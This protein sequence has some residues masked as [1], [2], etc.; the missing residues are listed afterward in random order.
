MRQKWKE[1]GVSPI[2]LPNRDNAVI[3]DVLDDRE[4]DSEDK[5]DEELEE[6]DEEESG[7]SDLNRHCLQCCM[8]TSGASD[9]SRHCPQ[10]YVDASVAS[11]STCPAAQGIVGTSRASGSSYP[12][13]QGRID[14]SVKR[15]NDVTKGSGIKMGGLMGNYFRN[16]DKK[17]GQQ[18]AFKN[19]GRHTLGCTVSYPDILNTHYSSYLEAAAETIAH[20]QFYIGYLEDVRDEKTNRKFNHLE[21][22]IYKA[23]HDNSTL[24]KLAVLALYQEAVSHS[25]ILV[26]RG[27]ANEP[28]N[29]LDLEPLHKK[30]R[31][32]IS[33]LI[34]EPSIIL[35]PGADPV[36]ATLGGLKEWKNPEAVRE[37]HRRAGEWPHLKA[38]F[39]A[40]LQG[41]LLTWEQFSSE[42]QDN[43]IIAALTPGE[44][45]LA[46]MPATN[47]V[48]EGALG[49][50]HQFSRCKPR[51]TELLFNAIFR[52][53]RNKT[54]EFRDEL[55]TTP[56]HE[57]FMKK[58][59]QLLQADGKERKRV[60]EIFEE[61][62][63]ELAEKRCRIAVQ[64]EKKKEKTG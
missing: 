56:E 39:I 30:V 15:A 28:K 43:G 1:L 38:I 45:D 9:L 47:D 55:L 32:H 23:L 20:P 64:D 10:G 37:I 29:A 34:G 31:T 60:R 2:P 62:Q 42:F 49:A 54:E 52:F 24:T 61:G 21:L 50:L 48:I 16:K 40:F 33:W 14:G 58:E 3:L 63:E 35:S 13:A 57:V 26:V 8:D 59:A 25:Y 4:R 19:H 7:A 36:G 5:D 44:R 53:R 6:E 12:I 18:D 11:S 51:G 46:W 17:K 41:A 22:N 27:K